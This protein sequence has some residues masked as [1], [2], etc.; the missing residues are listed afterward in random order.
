MATKPTKPTKPTKLTEPTEP[1]ESTKSTE[2]TTV[3][4]RN[5]QDAIGVEYDTPLVTCARIMHDTGRSCLVVTKLRNG[6]DQ[7]VGVLTDRDITIE[8]VAFSLDP[9]VITAGDIMARLPALAR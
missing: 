1:T 9:R 2:R 6:Q 8:A 7:P 3:N 5:L 4:G